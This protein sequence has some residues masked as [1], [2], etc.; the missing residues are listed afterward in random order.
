MLKKILNITKWVIFIALILELL[1]LLLLYSSGHK[2]PSSTLNPTYRDIAILI[3]LLVLV[4]VL[5]KRKKL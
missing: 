5:K 1:F 4:L 2:I 3:I